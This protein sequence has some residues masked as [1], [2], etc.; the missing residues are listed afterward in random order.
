[1]GPTLYGLRIRHSHPRHGKASFSVPIAILSSNTKSGLRNE[2]QAPP[3]KIRPQLEDFPHGFQRRAISFPGN[4]P[5]VL[6]FHLPLVFVQLAKRRIL[7]RAPLI[8]R[9][10]L[11]ESP[12]PWRWCR[13]RSSAPALMNS[14]PFA[15]G[16][17]GMKNLLA[18]IGVSHGPIGEQPVSC[19]VVR[20]GAAL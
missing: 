6:I 18:T 13:R 15:V 5:P 17:T 11:A 1:M 4:N 14:T 20:R 12:R 10:T 2:T 7:G 16:S 9:S 3:F 8:K 19:K